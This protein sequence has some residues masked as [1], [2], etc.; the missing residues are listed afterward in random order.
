MQVKAWLGTSITYRREVPVC[1]HT[2]SG[3]VNIHLKPIF[4]PGPDRPVCCAGSGS[5]PHLA[6]QIIFQS[7]ILI[8][9]LFS[10]QDSVGRTALLLLRLDVIRGLESVSTFLFSSKSFS[11]PPAQW[12]TSGAPQ[13]G[14][15]NRQMLKM[16]RIIKAQL[17]DGLA[18]VDVPLSLST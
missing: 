17:M 8:C 7:I 9:F 2:K 15:L 10:V 5:A 6:V 18:G 11:Q 14:R 1:T 12:N 16:T 4:G 13:I 3:F